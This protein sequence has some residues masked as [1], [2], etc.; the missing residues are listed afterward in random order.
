MASAT[1][2]SSATPPAVVSGIPALAGKLDHD[3]PAS[4]RAGRRLNRRR[5]DLFS[6]TFALPLLVL[7]ILF[8]VF[9]LLFLLA[10]SFWTVKNFALTPDFDVGN[11]ATMYGRPYFW[12]AY[13]RTLGLSALAAAVASVIAFP[14]AYGIAFKLSPAMQ[15]LAVFMLVTPFFTSYLVRVYSWQVFLADN[16]IINAAIGLVGLDRVPMLNTIFGTM[17]GYLTLTLPLVV[18]LQLFSL[19]Y[20]DRSLVEA[21]HNLR[22]GP[23]K[24]IFLVIIPLAKIGLIVAALFCFILTFGDFASPLYLGGAKQTTLSILIT[25]TTKAGQQWPRAAVIA[26]TMIVTLMVV[27]FGAIAFA[28]RKKQ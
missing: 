1:R 12:D 27:A 16:G 19:R 20:V 13:F 28:Y 15:R 4:R 3:R 18:L 7:Q 10:L 9:P 21:A 26:I 22:C 24:T 5:V 23:L 17:I 8:F 6:L 25:D 14:C 11:W 2:S